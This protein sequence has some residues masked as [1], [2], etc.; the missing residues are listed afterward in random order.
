VGVLEARVFAPGIAS[1][2]SLGQAV[3]GSE[4]LGRLPG[5]FFVEDAIE[6]VGGEMIKIRQ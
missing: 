1:Q 4:R 5:F 2:C 3:A 6:G